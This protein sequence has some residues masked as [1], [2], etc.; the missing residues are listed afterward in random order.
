M[1]HENLFSFVAD[2]QF[3]FVSGSFCGQH[4]LI[5]VIIIREACNYA[6][7][8]FPDLEF[9]ESKFVQFLPS[10]KLIWRLIPL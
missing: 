1:L 2:A 10:N 4:F 5:R 8:Y 9:V 7:N 6:Q 3:R